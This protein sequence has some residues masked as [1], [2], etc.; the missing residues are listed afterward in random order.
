MTDLER[1]CTVAIS[2]RVELLSR[3]LLSFPEARI[4]YSTSKYNLPPLVTL[5]KHTIGIQMTVLY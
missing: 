4:L 2:T 1:S 5:G 3:V